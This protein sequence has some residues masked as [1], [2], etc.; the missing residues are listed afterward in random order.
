M[1]ID[2]RVFR[3][4]AA[5]PALHV[6]LEDDAYYW[7]LQPWFARLATECGKQLDLYG[8][9]SFTRDDFGRLRRLLDEADEVARRGP[10]RWDVSVGRRIDPD[11][12]THEV[13]RV[14]HRARALALIARLRA[15]VEAA[16]RL[17]ARIECQ[18]D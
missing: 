13:R 15:I 18:G 1:G 4:E 7:F 17:D 9:V 2:V 12:I 5:D 3:G 10:A 16:A 6:V 14:V 11:G 8:D